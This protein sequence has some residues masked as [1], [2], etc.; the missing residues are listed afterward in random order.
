MDASSSNPG[1]VF[2]N[3]YVH[4]KE[5]D[6]SSPKAYLQPRDSGDIVAVVDVI[7]SE[8]QFRISIA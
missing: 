6:T 5:G 2:C 3:I 1:E 7:P 4:T 8:P